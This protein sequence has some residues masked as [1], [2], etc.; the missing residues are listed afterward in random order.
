[1]ADLTSPIFHDEEAARAYFEAMHWPDG[2]VCPWCS[3]TGPESIVKSE[4][5]TQRKG[6][7]LCRPC[8]R[9]FSVTI[10]TVMERSHVPLHKWAMAFHLMASSKKG[11]SAHQL[12]RTLGLGSYKTAWFMAHRIREAMRVDNPDLMGGPGETLEA[13]ETYLGP[14]VRGRRGKAVN[15]QGFKIG[16]A[17]KMKVVALVERGGRARSKHVHAVTREVVADILERN[18]DTASH[19]RTDEARHYMSLGHAFASHEAVHHSAKEYG[20]GE[21]HT[22]TVEGYFSIF[23]RGMK[24]VYQQC[25]EQHLQRYLNEFDFRYSNRSSLGIEDSERAAIAVRNAVGKRLTYKGTKE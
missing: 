13:D 8:F 20:R 1:M 21:A 9:L 10:G 18:A 5:K 17:D 19:L 16:V 2:P 6:L 11:I 23:K 15:A 3:S 25:G 4:N 22:N 12:M 14:K 24:G 7:W